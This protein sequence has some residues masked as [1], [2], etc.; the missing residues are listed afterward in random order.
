MVQNKNELIPSWGYLIKK[1]CYKETCFLCK[2]SPDIVMSKLSN[3]NM[4][5]DK[6]FW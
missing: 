3:K 1:K 5:E 4:K 6:I 2:I